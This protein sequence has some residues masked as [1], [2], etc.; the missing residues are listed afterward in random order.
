MKWHDLLFMHW[1]VPKSE[2]QQLIP[3][4]LE[5]D[6]YDGQGWIS[7]VPF[8]MSGVAPRWIPDLPW[9]SSFPELNV[10][11]YVNF[12]GKP[13][14]WFF[15]LD[16]TNPIA[17]RVARRWFYLKYMDARIHVKRQDS[18]IHYRSRRTHTDE[19]AAQLSVDYR[20]IGDPVT[21]KVGTLEHWLTSRYCLYAASHDGKIFRGE[22]DHLPWSLRNAQALIHKNTMLNR[23]SIDSEKQPALVHF[24]ERTDVVAWSLDLVG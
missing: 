7:V 19:P 3:D 16:A 12:Q 21:T 13:G 11:T 8:H 1:P 4:N 23:Y 6:L 20:P 22:I 2:L 5:L 9:M 24:A 18:W 15:S 14:V 17:V 10:R